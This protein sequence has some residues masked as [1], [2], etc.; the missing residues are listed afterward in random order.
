MTEKEWEDMCDV[1]SDM[2]TIYTRPYV[3]ILAG[4]TTGKPP[5]IG[6]GTFI[7]KDGIQLLTCE[8]VSRSNPTAF[9]NDDSGSRKLEPNIWC[10]EAA[11]NKDVAIAPVPGADWS[12]VSSSAQPLPLSNFAQRH[13]TVERELLF[14]RGIGGEN[15]YI[16]DYGADAILTGYCSQEKLETGDSDIFEILWNPNATTISSGTR[17]DARARIKFNNPAGFSGSLV[18]NTRFVELGCDFEKWSPGKA[19]VTGLLRR[20]DDTT[21]TLLAWRVEHVQS[22]LTE[23]PGVA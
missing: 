21:E 22:W 18:W 2:M 4:G 17:K 19:V 7:E 11:L 12:S 9:Y 1:V 5:E 13:T 3:A 10:A 14:F 23:P 20:F 15:A 6:T 16:S 8:H